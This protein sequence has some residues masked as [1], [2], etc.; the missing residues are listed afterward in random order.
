[1][2]NNRDGECADGSL[3]AAEALW[4][5]DFQGLYKSTQQPPEPP[6]TRRASYRNIT[7][8]SQHVLAQG[9]DVLYQ[10][11]RMHAETF[12]SLADALSP[13]YARSNSTRDLKSLNPM[14]QIFDVLRLF[15]QSTSSWSCLSIYWSIGRTKAEHKW[16][17]KLCEAVREGIPILERLMSTASKVGR[18]EQMVFITLAA[19]GMGKM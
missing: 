6:R 2:Y 8:P 19:R 4:G 11:I 14:I 1:M 3:H 5:Q 18:N 13:S 10:Q 15:A 9:P 12:L 17:Q 7:T 16:V